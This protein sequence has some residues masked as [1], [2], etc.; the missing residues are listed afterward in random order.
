MSKENKRIPFESLRIKASAES[1]NGTYLNLAL[2]LNLRV[3]ESI[4][5]SI[6]QGGGITEG[7]I[8]G[9]L[10][11]SMEQWLETNLLIIPP[12]SWSGLGRGLPV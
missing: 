1:Q 3:N 5:P 6:Y 12:G 9:G 4:H 2:E 7:D 8:W 11:G 10:L